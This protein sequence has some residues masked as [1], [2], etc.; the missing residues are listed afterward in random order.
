MNKLKNDFLNFKMA[1]QYKN[2]NDALIDGKEDERGQEGEGGGLQRELKEI[3]VHPDP[4]EMKYRNGII[5]PEEYFVAK[6]VRDRPPDAWIA[7]VGI[8]AALI[9]GAE[10]YAFSRPIF[11]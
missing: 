6:K 9:G 2:I 8:P 11:L 5:T 3:I 4:L 7:T 1:M 10:L